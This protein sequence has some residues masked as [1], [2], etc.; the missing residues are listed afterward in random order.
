M[1]LLIHSKGGEIKVAIDAM[2]CAELP[3]MLP[4]WEQRDLF[5]VDDTALQFCEK[6]SNL[7]H[8]KCRDIE[9][10]IRAANGAASNPDLARSMG[11]VVDAPKSVK[12][13]IRL[14]KIDLR[15]WKHWWRHADCLQEIKKSSQ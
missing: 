2:K 4:Q 3:G 10:R 14:L 6:I 15:K 8:S 1:G 11:V 13:Q 5:G 9:S 7:V 12:E